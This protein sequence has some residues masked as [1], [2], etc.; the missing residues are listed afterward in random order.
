MIRRPTLIGAAVPG[1]TH[2]LLTVLFAWRRGF[3][4][5]FNSTMRNPRRLASWEVIIST[6]D[7]DRGA[8]AAGDLACWRSEVGKVLSA[9]MCHPR[10]NRELFVRLAIVATL[11][12]RLGFSGGVLHRARFRNDIESP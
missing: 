3:G 8:I 6:A 11:G 10:P 2:R 7:G 5:G 9:A 12:C 1:V 4:G